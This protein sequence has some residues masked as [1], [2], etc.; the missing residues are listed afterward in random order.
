MEFKD[1]KRGQKIKFVDEGKTI[2][3]GV[4]DIVDCCSVFANVVDN[5][6]KQ[7]RVMFPHS[8]LKYLQPANIMETE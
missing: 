3:T 5:N 4:I 1:I 2:Y 7:M 6:G 8:N